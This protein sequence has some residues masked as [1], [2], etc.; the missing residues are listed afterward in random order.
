[1]LIS[2]KPTSQELY[3]KGKAGYENGIET[4]NK[5]CREIT[6]VE[7]ARALTMEDIIN[8]KY[9]EDE[10]KRDLIFGKENERLYYWLASSYVDAG[11]ANADFGLRYVSDGRVYNDDLWYSNGNPYDG[12]YGVRAVVSL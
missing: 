5:L 8:S 9:W 3:L 6:G 4:L 12:C 1:M 2:E 11:S 10:K 7:E